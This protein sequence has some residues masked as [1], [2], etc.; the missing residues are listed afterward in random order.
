[1]IYREPLVQVEANLA[2]WKCM[3]VSMTVSDIWLHS[4]PFTLETNYVE[5][6]G[7]VRIRY[8]ERGRERDPKHHAGTLGKR[9]AVPRDFLD[10]F[11][12]ER[13]DRNYSLLW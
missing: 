3:T 6:I 8:R 13:K 12:R 11:C 9:A 5:N 1:M 4:K 10:P 7:V 2:G